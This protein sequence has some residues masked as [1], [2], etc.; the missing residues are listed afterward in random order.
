MDLSTASLLTNT[1]IELIQRSTKD[2]LDSIKRWPDAPEENDSIYW[3]YAH[4]CKEDITD[5][6]K[7]GDYIHMKTYEQFVRI[8]WPVSFFLE[9]NL[10]SLKAHK[11][12]WYG[13]E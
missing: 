7:P 6:E 1:A 11:M 10:S 4:I 12:I 5:R 3:L 2:H 9:E 13:Y 8:S